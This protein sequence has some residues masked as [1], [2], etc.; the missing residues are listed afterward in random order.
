MFSMTPTTPRLTLLR[1]VRGALRDLLRRGLRRGDDDDLGA[2]QELRHRERDVAGAGRHVDDEEVGLAPVHVG[3]ELL[4][5]LVQHRAAPDDRLV[6]AGEEAHRDQ[7][8]AVR[9]G[10]HDHVVDDGRRAVDAEHAR[11][12][13]APHV[14]VDRGDPVAPLRERDREVRGDRR[15]AD[16][17]LAR[18]DREDPGA[19]VGERVRAAARAGARRRALAAAA[20]RAPA[21][22]SSVITVRS[23]STARDAGERVDRLGDPAG[24]LGSQRAARRRSARPSR[25][26]GRPSIAM[27]RTMS[28]STIERW[29]SGSS[30]GPQRLEDLGFG[31]HAAP[32]PAPG[33]PLRRR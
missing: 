11:H 29:S 28:S 33:F 32:A 4:E 5:R 31:R 22:S 15:L 13:E 25:R 24:D 19:G 18:R 26:H 27:P 7:R 14:G 10:R 3:E 17:A 16:A 20:A 12:R 21:R 6:L 30:T 1:H 9:V 2:R 23:T 8:H